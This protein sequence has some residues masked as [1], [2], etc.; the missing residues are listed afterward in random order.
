MENKDLIHKNKLKFMKMA[1]KEAQKAFA[2]DEVPIGCIIV[3]KTGNVLAKSHNQVEK[4]NNATLHAEL[5]AIQK[6]TKKVGEKYLMNT[7]IFITLEP[8]PMCATAISLAK[9]KN[10]YIGAEDKKGGAILNG[11]KLYQNAKNLYKPNIY[12]NI[13]NED[14]SQILKDFFKIVRNSKN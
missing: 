8:C 7:S 1:Y 9:I 14:C 5:V 13:L 10:V 2:K 12:T 11:I 4:K 6:A 3:D